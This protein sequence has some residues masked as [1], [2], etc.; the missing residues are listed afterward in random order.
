MERPKSA[1][2]PDEPGA[3][4]LDQVLAQI[5]KDD[6]EEWEYEYST[7]ET[8]VCLAA[9][10]LSPKA[11]VAHNL[12]RHFTS[13]L[14]SRI[15]NSRSFQKG[16]HSTAVVDITRTGQSQTSPAKVTKRHHSRNSPPVPTA[17]TRTRMTA[18]TTRRMR[19]RNWG[20]TTKTTARP[21]TQLS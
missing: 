11:P 3:L 13:R 4:P 8:E 10:S 14:S 9:L 17:I 7:S 21:L 2:T 20:K 5:T 12:A 6:Q 18:T 19:T 16:E 15:Q 1:F